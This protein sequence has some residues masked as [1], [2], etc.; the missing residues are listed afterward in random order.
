VG[1][2]AQVRW[3][4]WG[5]DVRLGD[6]VTVNGQQVLQGTTVCLTD[7]ELPPP[8]EATA[9]V[10]ARAL[11]VDYR[12]RNVGQQTAAATFAD[13]GHDPSTFLS[14][15][16]SGWTNVVQYGVSNNETLSRQQ[17][18][19]AELGAGFSRMVEDQVVLPIRIDLATHALTFSLDA[20]EQVAWDLSPGRQTVVHVAY[21]TASLLA[22]HRTCGCAGD[23][24]VGAAITIGSR[25][26]RV[27][28]EVCLSPEDMGSDGRFA[29]QVR[30]S[31]PMLDEQAE[32]GGGSGVS[33]GEV[34]SEWSRED[35][36]G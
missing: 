2:G 4:G 19:R 9:D 15:T 22:E 10:N 3:C 7:V 20:Y 5:A 17:A 24:R 8:S 31:Q 34:V 1:G 30:V 29:V 33:C 18:G 27:G 36:E 16:T 12:E 6:T 28:G 26:V 21:C 14:T 35:R 25:T 13:Q 32:R 11:L 23:L